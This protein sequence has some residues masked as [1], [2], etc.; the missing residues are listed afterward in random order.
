[1]P[2]PTPRHLHPLTPWTEA[3]PLVIGHFG[4]W[5]GLAS[6]QR[7]CAREVWLERW[8]G[9]HWARGGV[10]ARPRAREARQVNVEAGRGLGSGSHRLPAPGLS[11]CPTA[12]CG[13]CGPG[14]VGARPRGAGDLALRGLRCLPGGLPSSRPASSLLAA[15][16][17]ESAGPSG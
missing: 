7:V 8:R 3:G 9:Q 1:M 11:L 2:G 13:V 5:Q 17:C 14:L 15:R 10:H 4:S 6:V 12:L 16:L